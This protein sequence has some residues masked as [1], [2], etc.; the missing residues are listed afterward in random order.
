[1]VTKKRKPSHPTDTQGRVR[2]AVDISEEISVE[3]G[4]LAAR[5]RLSK[6]AL[7]E[8]LIMNAVRGKSL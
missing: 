6:R 3:F 4:V 8:Q 2:I 5:R 1:M 7:M